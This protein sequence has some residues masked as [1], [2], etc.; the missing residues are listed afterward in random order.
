[1][2]KRLNFTV[3]ELIKIL[4]TLPPNLPVVVSGY[5]SGY[6]NFYYPETVTLKHEPD[7]FY[8]DGEFQSTDKDDSD[9][10]EAVALR[11]VFRDD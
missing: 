8:K 11:R 5:N 4:Q 1:M 9:T 2:N 6:E 3:E 10:F 7:N